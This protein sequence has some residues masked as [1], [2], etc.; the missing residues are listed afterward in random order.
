VWE[1]E[2]SFFLRTFNNLDIDDN[3]D[4]D[5]NDDGVVKPPTNK[6]GKLIAIVI[7]DNDD[8]IS[9]RIVDPTSNK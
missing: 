2:D 4:C 5:D 8:D 1:R 7:D 6:M 9:G 3:D